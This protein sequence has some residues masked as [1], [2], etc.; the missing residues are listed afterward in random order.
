MLVRV[1]VFRESLAEVRTPSELIAEPFERFLKLPTPSAQ[2]SAADDG[3]DVYARAGAGEP[4]GTGG[5]LAT[6]LDDSGSPAIVAADGRE[7]RRI[8]G[9]GP[10]L[11]RGPARCDIP[12]SR[13]RTRAPA[14]NGVLALDWNRDFKMDFAL[15][16][17]GGLRLF[18]QTLTAPSR[19]RRRRPAGMPPG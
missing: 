15:A 8:G 18:T 6:A 2:P 19:T 13:R 7:L 9:V 12:V 11:K 17:R 3:A 10:A 5:V 16:G 14:A 1:T 4:D